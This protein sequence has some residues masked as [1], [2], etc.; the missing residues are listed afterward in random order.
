MRVPMTDPTPPR[1]APAA[2]PEALWS[3]GCLFILRAAGE[4]MEAIEAIAP[5]GYSPPLHRHDFGSESFYVLGGRVRFVIG[6]DDAVSGPGAFVRAPP[7]GA[8]S[9]E[10]LGD[11]PFRTLSVV[12]P[13]GLWA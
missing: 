8:H 1:S 7:G 4:E 10:P 12:A 5:P 3:L 2:P 13:A 11:E 6:D 9:F